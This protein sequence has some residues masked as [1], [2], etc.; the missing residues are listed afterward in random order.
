MG[1]LPWN[2]SLTYV[3]LVHR[4]SE[5]LGKSLLSAGARLVLV[6]EVGFED[7]MLLLCEARLDVG[8]GMRGILSMLFLV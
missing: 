6:L 1:N 8:T 7:I 2:A 3:D 4:D 5:T